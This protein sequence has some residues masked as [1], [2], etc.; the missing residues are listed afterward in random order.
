MSEDGDACVLLKESSFL[1]AWV[2]ECTGGVAD[3]QE[4]AVGVGIAEGVE[5]FLTERVLGIG[6]RRWLNEKRQRGK[7]NAK[8]VCIG[9]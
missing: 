5:L 1:I 3:D 7:I 2:A 9:I 4:A 6:G 8:D